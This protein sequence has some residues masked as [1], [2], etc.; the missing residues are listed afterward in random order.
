M[1]FAWQ[2]TFR[3]GF[4]PQMSV[5]ALTALRRALESDDARLIT[6]ATTV[7][8]PLQCVQE[9]PVEAACPIALSGWLGHNLTTVGEVETYFARL[10]HAADERLGEPAACRYVLN[11]IDDTPR[12][13]MRQALL[14]EVLLAL[15]G[16]M[17]ADGAA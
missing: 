9:S 7:P 12:Q 11:W 5:R 1:L 3:L 16:R 6:S 4:A 17:P 8:P 15:V 10:C 13:T 2:R 14:T